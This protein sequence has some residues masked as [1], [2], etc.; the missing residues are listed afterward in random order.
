MARP[1]RP[2]GRSHSLLRFLLAPAVGLLVVPIAAVRLAGSDLPSFT[3]SVA[4]H[5]GKRLEVGRSTFA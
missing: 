1:L 5:A 3:P 4:P 2:N